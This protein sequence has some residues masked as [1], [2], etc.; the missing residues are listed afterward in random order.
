VGEETVAYAAGGRSAHPS[1][2]VPPRPGCGGL[3]RGARSWLDG[4]ALLENLSGRRY[5]SRR[6]FS[7]A[8]EADCEALAQDW[9]VVGADLRAAIDDVGRSAVTK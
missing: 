3:L 7:T 4:V 8:A 1:S 5:H 9:A 2:G 6:G